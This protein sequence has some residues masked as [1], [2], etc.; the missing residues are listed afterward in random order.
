VAILGVSACGFPVVSGFASWVMLV[1][2]RAVDVQLS[3]SLRPFAMETEFG[4]TAVVRNPLP[5]VRSKG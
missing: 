4:G 1:A 2:S 3:A 5:L